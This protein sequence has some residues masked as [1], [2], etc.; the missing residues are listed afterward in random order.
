MADLKA[1]WLSLIDAYSAESEEAIAA[2]AQISKLE[3][4]EPIAE[5]ARREQ[6]QPQIDSVS[7]AT[8]NSPT[9]ATEEITVYTATPAEI[10]YWHAS[11][12]NVF[13]QTLLR[14]YDLD[15]SSANVAAYNHFKIGLDEKRHIATFAIDD[16]H[17]YA[18]EFN[19]WNCAPVNKTRARD[20][21]EKISAIRI[22]TSRFKAFCGFQVEYFD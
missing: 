4:E 19:K 22:A 17:F 1:R 12:C 2:P 16:T 10:N 11:G 18:I 20:V 7:E 9:V 14:E 3:N 21:L 15:N 13:L 8:E 5:V 6:A